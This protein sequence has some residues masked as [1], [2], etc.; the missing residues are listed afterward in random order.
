MRMLERKSSSGES[1]RRAPRLSHFQL[2]PLDCYD[3]SATEEA[4]KWVEMMIQQ[5]TQFHIV[6]RWLKSPLEYVFLCCTPRL[7]A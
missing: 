1:Q 7:S 6:G 5:M 3:R 2:K 4:P